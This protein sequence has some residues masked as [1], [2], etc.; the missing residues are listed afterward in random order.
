MR[1]LLL[2]FEDNWADECDFYLNSVHKVTTE[3]YLEFTKAL[4]YIQEYP[5]EIFY[6]FGTNEDNCYENG[7]DFLSHLSGT[8]ITESEYNTIKELGL[9]TPGTDW[10]WYILE[11]EAECRE[12]IEYHKEEGIE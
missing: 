4:K 9:E 6:N 12:N 8:F 3:E 7:K 10:Y 11:Q 5:Y 1:Y 2:K